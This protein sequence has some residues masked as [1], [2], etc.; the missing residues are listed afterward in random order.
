M[1]WGRV[2]AG[3]I[4]AGVV[5]SAADFVQHGVLLADTYKKYSE[6]FTQTQASPMYFLAVAL[7]VGI[8]TAI[9]F[10]KTRA[11]WAPGWKG[12]LAFGFFFALAIFF[13]NF[14]QPLVI[15]GFPYHLAWCWGG[16]NVVDGLLAGAVMGAIIPRE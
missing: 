16:I 9:L 15:G 6:A 14:Y 3:G 10:G 8:C 4:A 13:M 12:G 7:C 1:S 2:L 11:S 5:T